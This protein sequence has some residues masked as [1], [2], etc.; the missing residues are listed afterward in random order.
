MAAFAVIARGLERGTLPA[1]CLGVSQTSPKP[2]ETVQAQV[3]A[4]MAVAKK[5]TAD[6]KEVQAL[7]AYKT[8]SGLMLG[9]PWLQHRTAELARKLKQPQVAALHYR[10]AAA[11][12]IRAG[13]PKRALAPLRMAWQVSISLLP[14]ESSAFVTVTLELANVQRELGFAAD[15]RLT[16]VGANQALKAAGSTERVPSAVD[17]ELRSSRP[18]AA[19]DSTN[20]PESGVKVNV[21]STDGLLGRLRE[22]VKP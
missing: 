19:R 3:E 15:A 11:A 14:A 6:R 21:S 5:L 22:T 8:A 18:P 1:L 13:F 16:F 17:L 4:L 12:F 9:A 20:P 10:R 7:E 2:S